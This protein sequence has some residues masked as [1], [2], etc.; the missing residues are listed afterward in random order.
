MLIVFL[1]CSVDSIYWLFD[2]AISLQYLLSPRICKISATW[3][4]YY[5]NT[6]TNNHLLFYLWTL[7]FYLL[8]PHICV[9]SIGLMLILRFLNLV[10]GQV[11]L[12]K[13]S[14]HILL[15]WLWM[16]FW[17]SAG[18]TF[19]VICL[20]LLLLIRQSFLI[21]QLYLLVL[22]PCIKY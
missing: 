15:V 5:S 2:Y 20:I 19:L 18:W 14:Y 11:L 8:N 4:G 6:I 10:N 9:G 16:D 17:S 1:I 12:P 13:V 22:D 3:T 21:A 7:L